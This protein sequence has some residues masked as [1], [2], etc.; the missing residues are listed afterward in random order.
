MDVVIA[1]WIQAEEK[2]TPEYLIENYVDRIRERAR[3]NFLCDVETTR[4]LI[5]K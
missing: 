2:G 4:M 1:E 3:G 5:R